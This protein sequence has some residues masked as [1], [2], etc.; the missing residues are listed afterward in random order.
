[1]KVIVN[2][3]SRYLYLNWANITFS[4]FFSMSI[5][6]CITIIYANR[7]RIPTMIYYLEYLCAILYLEYLLISNHIGTIQTLKKR[8]SLTGLTSGRIIITIQVFWFL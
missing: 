2:R 6:T 5:T 3:S 1:M 7:I 8:Y 4:A